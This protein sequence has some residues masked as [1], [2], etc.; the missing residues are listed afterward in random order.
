MFLFVLTGT[1]IENR[2]DDLYSLLQLVDPQR[3]PSGAST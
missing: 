1:P 2:L 3:P